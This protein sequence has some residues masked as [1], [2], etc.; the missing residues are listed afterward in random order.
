M[1]VSAFLLALCGL[2]SVERKRWNGNPP[3]IAEYMSDPMR[4]T[5]K[6]SFAQ[7]QVAALGRRTM[8]SAIAGLAVGL[9]LVI[10]AAIR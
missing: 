8:F 7:L 3:T 10:A 6:S 5:R 1:S 9:L 2:G 4:R